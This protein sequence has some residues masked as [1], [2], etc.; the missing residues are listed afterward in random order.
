MTGLAAQELE[1]LRHDDDDDDDRENM[2]C[3]ARVLPFMNTL[4]LPKA[5]CIPC[6]DVS[7]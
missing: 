6:R 2:I 1:D 3:C 5:L 4:T 7:C